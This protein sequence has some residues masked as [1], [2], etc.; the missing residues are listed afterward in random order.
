MNLYYVDL[1]DVSEGIQE[2]L[3]CWRNASEIRHAMIHQ[4]IIS[5]EEHKQWLKNVL[6]VESNYQIRVCFLEESPFGVIYLDD[7]DIANRSAC[8]GLYIGEKR[9]QGKGLGKLMVRSVLNWGFLELDLD[10]LYT[11]VLADNTNALSLYLKEGFSIEGNW[12]SHVLSED[13]HRID[14][15]WIGMLSSSWRKAT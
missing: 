4:K 12:R 1:K 15:I 2:Q 10:R 9:F 5:L 8:W 6:H 11:S 7:I 3:L 14:L 13:G